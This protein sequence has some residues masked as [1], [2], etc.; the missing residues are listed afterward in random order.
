MKSVQ[1]IVFCSFALLPLIGH[2]DLEPIVVTGTK[3]EQ[4][5]SESAVPVEIITSEQIRNSVATDVADIIEI[6]SG[7]DLARNGDFGKT[8]SIFIRGSESNHTVILIDGVKINPATIALA[9]LQN[10]SPDIIERIEIVKG[11]RSSL[12]GSEAIGGVRTLMSNRRQ[13][14]V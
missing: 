8:T 12:Y 4:P 13:G 9:P 2:A 11:P 14:H 7:L 5:L 6:Y 10:I 3:T 1:S